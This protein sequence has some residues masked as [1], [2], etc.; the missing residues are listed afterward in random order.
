MTFCP[1]ALG[2]GKVFLPSKDLSFVPSK[3][4]WVCVSVWESCRFILFQ[5]LPSIFMSN[6]I[7]PHQLPLVMVAK[8]PLECFNILFSDVIENKIKKHTPK[9]QGQ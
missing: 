9:L 6:D 4:F 7:R 2:F 1:T 5:T 8:P 3:L